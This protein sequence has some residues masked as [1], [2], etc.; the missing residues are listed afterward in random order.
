MIMKISTTSVLE[1][2]EALCDADERGRMETLPPLATDVT[3]NELVEV[4]KKYEK[5]K[6]L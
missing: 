5:E 3:I 2:I 4:V 1:Q 6:S